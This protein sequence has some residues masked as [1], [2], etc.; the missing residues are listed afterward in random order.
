VQGYRV[1]FVHP[2]NP[3]E[4]LIYNHTQFP[5]QALGREMRRMALTPLGKPGAGTPMIEGE[6]SWPL[7]WYLHGTDYVFTSDAVPVPAALDR[8]PLL[9]CDASYAEAHAVLGR[10]YD[11]EP[12]GLRCAWVPD[13]L[14][15]LTPLSGALRERYPNDPSPEPLSDAD[16]EFLASRRPYYGWGAWRTLWHYVIDPE[17]RPWGD[18]DVVAQPLDITVGRRRSAAAEHAAGTESALPAVPD[19]PD[20]PDLP[21]PE[22][23][24]P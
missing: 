4:R 9:A 3:G 12:V 17:R 16:A 1:C 24:A 22:P 8:I 18:P 6:A 7:L 21:A 19:V 20:V 13:P 15:L 2:T 10:Q 14:H 11:L 5:T 23:V